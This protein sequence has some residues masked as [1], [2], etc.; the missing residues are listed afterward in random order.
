MDR[1]N[2]KINLII[3]S[4]GKGDEMPVPK[5]CFYCKYH[6]ITEQDE[7]GFWQVVSK[8]EIG[9]SD[10]ERN[11]DLGNLLNTCAKPEWCRVEKGYIENFWIQ[12]TILANG[13]MYIGKA[14]ESYTHNIEELFEYC[15][16]NFGEYIGTVYFEDW[17]VENL[18]H[19]I[20]WAFMNYEKFPLS[21]DINKVIRLITIYLGKIY[22]SDNIC[23]EI[24][25]VQSNPLIFPK[26]DEVIDLRPY[27][28]F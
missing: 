21:N 5:A 27:A 3:Q 22:D 16:T 12:E 8:C 26:Y 17:D 20:G 24:L 9:K 7:N 15:K 23:G 6:T 28:Y 13:K 25:K 18:N 14:F 1:Y 2:E 4:K 19:A 11:V 10:E